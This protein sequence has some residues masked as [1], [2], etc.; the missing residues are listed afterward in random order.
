MKFIVGK[1][2]YFLGQK[3]FYSPYT[4]IERKT[5]TST[6]YVKKTLY[7]FV[8]SKESTIPQYN[9]FLNVSITVVITVILADE[10]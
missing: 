2:L 4:D 8:I 10:G 9:M 3:M 1:S 5:K 6:K 7:A